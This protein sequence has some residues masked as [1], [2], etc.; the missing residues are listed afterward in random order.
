MALAALPITS[1]ALEAFCRRW[2]ISEL[3]VFGSALRD[4]FH[5]DSDLDLIA[6]FMP[7]AHWSAIDHLRMEHEL[8]G[9]IG[10]PVDIVTREALDEDPNV[11]RR[12]RIL[13][14]ARRIYAA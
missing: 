10:R 6:T 13:G 4:D 1:A 8:E 14:S 12:E 5:A 11:L 2:R 7:D 9:L 3:A